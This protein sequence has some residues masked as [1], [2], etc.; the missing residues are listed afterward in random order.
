M[1]SKTSNISPEES[2]L[3]KEIFKRIID[4]EK[5][6]KIFSTNINPDYIKNEFAKLL[7]LINSKVDN[8]DFHD[9]RETTSKYI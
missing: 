9:L 5:H 6:F 7:D 4:L 2:K 8:K 1:A 3:Q